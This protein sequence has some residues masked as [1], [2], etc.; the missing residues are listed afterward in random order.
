MASPLSR[1]FMYGLLAGGIAAQAEPRA[2]R[3]AT[4]NV[5]LNRPKAGDLLA[6]LRAG[7]SAQ[8]R[9]VAAIIQRTRPD[10]LLLNEFDWDEKSEALACFVRTY[11]GEGQHGEA[12]IQYPHLFVAAINTGVPT[13]LDLDHDGATD[14][15]GDAFGFGAFPGQ[16]GMAV[17]SRLPI[18]HA[19]VRTFQKLLW[20]DMPDARLPGD[21]YSDEVKTRLRLSSKSH[22]DVPIEL[23]KSTLHFLVSHPTPPVFDGVE[24]RNGRRNADE[25][26]FWADYIDPT[27][28]AWIHDDAGQTGG[29][30]PDARFV[31]AGDL[32]ADPNDG[33]SV[34]GA[35]AQLLTHALI[36]A[37]AVPTSPGGAAAASRQRGVNAKH[38]GDPAADTGDFADARVGNLRL[39]YVLPARTLQAQRQ[40]VFWP[41]TADAAFTLVGDGNPVVSSDHRLVWLDVDMPPQ[42]RPGHPTRPSRDAFGELGDARFLAPFAFADHELTLVRWWTDTCPFCADS[43]PALDALRARYASAGLAVVAMYHP[44][45]PRAVPDATIVAHAERLGFHGTLAA[46]LTWSKLADLQARGAPRRATSIS[47][48]VDRSG[49][50][51]WT[52]PGPRLHPG[53]AH[54][55][56]ADAYE[57]LRALLADRL[58]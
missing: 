27:R 18:A 3:V 52:H 2:L 35:I 41:T 51:V 38:R 12:P 25:I 28:S 57:E 39:D 46:D 13:G 9:A 16:Y 36:D 58:R 47:V 17:L 22:W 8:A 37:S 40:G 24:D 10:V 42:E 44:K 4:F 30:E 43:L 11:L 34:E 23:G 50:I 6:E 19:Q 15:P 29:L 14:G 53:S 45:P 33:D 1:I 5:A 54:P 56:A 7:D 32:N 49:T 21:W 31:I 20:R 48:L 55:E 26:R